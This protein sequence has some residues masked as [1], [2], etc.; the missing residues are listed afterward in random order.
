MTN[1]EM[2]IILNKAKGDYSYQ[3]ARMQDPNSK[4]LQNLREVQYD[5]RRKE[6]MD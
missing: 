4:E 2:K 5:N 3:K 1:E 6:T